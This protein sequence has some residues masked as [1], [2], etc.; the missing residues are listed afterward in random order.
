M[1]RATCGRETLNVKIEVSSPFQLLLSHPTLRKGAFYPLRPWLPPTVRSVSVCTTS[2][3]HPGPNGPCNL[4]SR[5]QVLCD[6]LF[7][8]KAKQ[9]LKR[10]LVRQENKIELQMSKL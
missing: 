6:F 4:F 10:G 3:K 8:P 7:P 2:Y 1:S 9:S 5:E